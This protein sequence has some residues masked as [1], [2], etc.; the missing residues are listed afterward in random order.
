MTRVHAHRLSDE[1]LRAELAGEDTILFIGTDLD[2]QE[3]ER[4]V[5]RL[6]LSEFYVVSTQRNGEWSL[7]RISVRPK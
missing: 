6:G 1:E 2:E 3:V 4:Q 5:E 7:S